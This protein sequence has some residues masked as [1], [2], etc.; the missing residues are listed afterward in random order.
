VGLGE[1]EAGARDT[2]PEFELCY[3][4]ADGDEYRE[5]PAVWPGL[6]PETFMSAREFCQARDQKHL[7]R[8]SRGA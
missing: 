3:L 8:F 5:L 4:D 6:R 1:G 7:L 2:D